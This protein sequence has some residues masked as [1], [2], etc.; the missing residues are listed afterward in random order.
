MFALWRAVWRAAGPSRTVAVGMRQ[1]QRNGM[2]R[3]KGPTISG[4]KSGRVA[5]RVEWR[6]SRTC[7]RIGRKSGK[8]L[9]SRH[10]RGID[11]FNVHA[12]EGDARRPDRRMMR[13]GKA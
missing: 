1:S 13:S 4:R 6:T 8:V 10:L 11:R 2:G 5:S 9:A 3:A 7:Y 12:V